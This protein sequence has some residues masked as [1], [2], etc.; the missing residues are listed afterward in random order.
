MLGRLARQEGELKLAIYFDNGLART[1][2]RC[3]PKGRV[4][5]YRRD[6]DG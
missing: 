4:R 2:G 5:F 6:Q 1:R 3:V